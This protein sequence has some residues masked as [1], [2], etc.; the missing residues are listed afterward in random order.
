MAVLLLRFERPPCSCLYALGRFA[1]GGESDHGP[2][3]QARGDLSA[4]EL[5]QLREPKL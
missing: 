3:Y 1:V 4:S 2:E 5:D